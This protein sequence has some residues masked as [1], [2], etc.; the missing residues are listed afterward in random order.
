MSLHFNKYPA[1]YPRVRITEVLLCS[2]EITISIYELIAND[3]VLL[4]LATFY[5]T[6]TVKNY[7]AT[8]IIPC[9]VIILY[10]GGKL[11]NNIDD[12][13]ILLTINSIIN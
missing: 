2:D 3:F 5:C 6:V 1:G 7:S 8:K 9:N 10:S 4:F 12:G 11:S 13:V